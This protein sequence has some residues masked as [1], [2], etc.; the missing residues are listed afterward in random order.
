MKRSYGWGAFASFVADLTERKRDQRSAQCVVAGDDRGV[1]GAA[2]N[3]AADLA[4]DSLQ[5]LPVGELSRN[6]L[7]RE[8]E[9]VRDRRR[10]LQ[11]RQRIRIGFDEGRGY[12]GAPS[13]HDGQRQAVDGAKQQFAQHVERLLF[14]NAGQRALDVLFVDDFAGAHAILQQ[15]RRYVQRDDFVGRLEER[16]R[17]NFAYRIADEAFG[18][19]R[20]RFEVLNIEG[21][22]D[23]DAGLA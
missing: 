23:A 15:P 2:Q 12:R 4:H 16:Q 19:R 22:D 7:E 8:V 1:E 6:D 5:P 18:D 3:L 20:D 14:E 13:L 10:S 21:T 11:E 9:R 17:N